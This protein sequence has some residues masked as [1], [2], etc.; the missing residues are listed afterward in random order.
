M[1]WAQW[2]LKDNPVTIPCHGLAAPHQL[3]LPRAPTMA[4]GTSRDGAPTLLWA[5]WVWCVDEVA[6]SAFVLIQGYSN[7][8]R[9]SLCST[10]LRKNIFKKKKVKMRAKLTTVDVHCFTDIG[11]CCRYSFPCYWRSPAGWGA[12]LRLNV[13][14]K[15]AAHTSHLWICCSWPRRASEHCKWE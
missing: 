14:Q 10:T 4:L 6:V 1:V 15:P 11:C 9:V 5:S 8:P 12:A 3:R 13:H 7:P 2:N